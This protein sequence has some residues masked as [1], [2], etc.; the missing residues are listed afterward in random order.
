MT[1]ERDLPAPTSAVLRGI[2]R[3]LVQHQAH[4][5]GLPG[6]Q[7]HRR[8]LELEGFCSSP[9]ERLQRVSERMQ[10][11]A[12]PL[13]VEQQIVGAG[14]RIHP[15]EKHLAVLLGGASAVARAASARITANES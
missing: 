5:K 15:P 7:P 9:A 8:A 1:G 2:R 10:L 3:Q 4:G 13:A 14:K 11:G 6:A 12:F